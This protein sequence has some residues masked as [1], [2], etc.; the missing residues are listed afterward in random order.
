MLNATLKKSLI[1]VVQIVVALLIT[2]L[3]LM[4]DVV[5]TPPLY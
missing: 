1:V 2:A 4:F 5:R 3:L